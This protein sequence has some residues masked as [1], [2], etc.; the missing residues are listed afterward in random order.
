[1]KEKLKKLKGEIDNSTIVG[2]FNT[3]L[4]IMDTTIG[5]K[6]YKEKENLSKTI[7]Q[8]NLT[9][10]HRTF[11]LTKAKYTFFS[12]VPGTFSV[13]DHKTNLKKLS[14]IEI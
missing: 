10:I 3:I 1:M 14:K 2:D 5:Q 8:L 12:S 13:I 11:H 7:N 4:S 9:D 6:S